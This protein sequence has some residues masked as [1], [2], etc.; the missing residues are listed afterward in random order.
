MVYTMNTFHQQIIEN[1]K[2]HDGKYVNMFLT[3][4]GIDDVN[5]CDAFD[6]LEELIEQGTVQRQMVSLPSPSGKGTTKAPLYRYN[7]TRDL[8]RKLTLRAVD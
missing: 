6:A 7:T 4:E 5:L 8:A 3:V 2:Q 1:L